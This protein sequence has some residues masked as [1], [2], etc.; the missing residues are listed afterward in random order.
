MRL[1][2]TGGAGFIGSNFVRR[3]L[4]ATDDSIV[5]LDKLTYA[6]NR[7]NLAECEAQPD[8]ASR[9]RFVRGDICDAP[10]V[11]E[12][13]ADAD[14]VINFAAESHV[15]RSIMDAEAFLRTGVIGVH[16]L[17]EAVRLATDGRKPRFV[18]ISTDEVYGEKPEGVSSEGDA[19][20]PRSPYASAK[21]AGELLVHAY[22][23]THGID[24]VITRGSNTYGP[25][26]HPEKVIPLFITNALEDEPLPLYGDGRQQRDWLFVDDHAD[27]V[28]FIL[29]RGA[30]GEAYNI[31]GT[32]QLPNR[33]VTARILSLV[34]RP[35]SLV[36]GV[37][38][39][40]GMTC[41]MRWTAPGW[42][43]LAGSQRSASTTAWRER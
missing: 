39:A 35:W 37:P 26:Q 23:V 32:G 33:E 29:D 14:A 12:L 1:L 3:R 9:F 7:Q 20:R 11:H 19:L 24:A 36:R 31:C 34:D 38:T 8:V 27:A 4:A 42:R 43:S 41:A 30:S 13:V 28:G 21:A 6:G 22:H 18:Q 16:T 5:V 15:D 2:V 17:L 40:P 25:N 10:L